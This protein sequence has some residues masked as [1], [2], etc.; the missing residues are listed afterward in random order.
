M[1]MCCL[2]GIVL[3]ELMHTAGFWHEQSRQDRDQHVT[4]N[5]DNIRSHGNSG[6]CSNSSVFR[7]GMEVNFL[8]YDLG[9][10][11]HL[12]A[13]YDTCSVMH[14]GPAAFAKVGPKYFNIFYT[15]SL[16]LYIYC[17]DICQ[18]KM[19]QDSRVPTIVA[20]KKTG[21]QLGQR[22]GLSATDIR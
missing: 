10:V 14:Y 5:W 15:G 7:A 4:I 8:K 22:E 9:K 17:V 2:P 3:H 21:C 13:P 16:Y 11:D 20:K 12:G 6:N 18:S 1:W 19:H